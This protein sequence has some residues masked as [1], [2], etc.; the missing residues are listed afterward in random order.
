MSQTD[1]RESELDCSPYAIPDY[2]NG[3]CFYVG[4]TSPILVDVSG[5]GFKLSDGSGG[6]SFDLN[7]DG[8]A[9]RLSWT[10]AN[11]VMMP[12]SRSIVMATVL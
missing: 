1:P 3:T 11:G 12:S 6:V 7:S 10:I 8:L 4:N 2:Q 9:E 5:D